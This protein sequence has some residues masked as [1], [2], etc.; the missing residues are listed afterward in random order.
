M[1]RFP[2]HYVRSL[3]AY[4]SSMRPVLLRSA[5]SAD[6]TRE[7]LLQLSA[8]KDVHVRFTRRGEVLVAATAH[9]SSG[10]GSPIIPWFRGRV[11]QEGDQVVLRGEIGLD[12]G[13]AIGLAM[14]VVMFVFVL[15]LNAKHFGAIVLGLAALVAFIVF[16][17]SIGRGDGDVILQRLTEA[18]GER[19]AA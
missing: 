19:T 4:Y 15:L 6:E 14:F 17:Y 7:R 2:S 5:F 18:A 9:A 8:H 3:W 1:R 13:L 10:R 12:R 11:I 16:A